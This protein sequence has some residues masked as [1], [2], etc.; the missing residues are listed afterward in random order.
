M[1]ESNAGIIEQGDANEWDS[2]FLVNDT[3]ETREE[4]CKRRTKIITSICIIL[5]TILTVHSIY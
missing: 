3:S 1:S 2:S 5:H 4:I